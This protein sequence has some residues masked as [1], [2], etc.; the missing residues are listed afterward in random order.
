VRTYGRITV[1][2]VLKWATAVTDENGANDLVYV[3]ALIQV[4]KLNLGE[5]PF[6]SNIGIP[7][8]Q[9]VVQQVFPD[10]YAALT[11]Q[12]FSPYFASIL[13]TRTSNNYPPTYNVA[14]TTYQGV[15]IN[16]S[17]PIPT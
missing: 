14:V 13:I 16:A 3:T 17:V 10:Y 11:Q 15:K 9:S 7:G 1:N 12:L 5:S 6:Y 2:G 4:L 8:A